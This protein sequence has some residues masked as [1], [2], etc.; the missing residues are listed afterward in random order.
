MSKTYQIIHDTI[1][2]QRAILCLICERVSHNP[3]DV[4]KLYCA[5][6]KMFHEDASKIAV[7]RHV[8]DNPPV[9]ATGQNV[10][11]LGPH[12]E[13]PVGRGRHHIPWIRPS[14]I[15]EA[16]R[17]ALHWTGGSA[18]DRTDAD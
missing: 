12:D 7:E 8:G 14:P 4:E 18:R 1:T 9:G 3:N 13:R 17:M 16:G 11:Q 15:R 2:G 6:C 10:G 5:N